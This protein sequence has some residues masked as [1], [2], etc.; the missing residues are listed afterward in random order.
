MRVPPDSR[1]S[2]L[3]ALPVIWKPASLRE[4]VRMIKLSLIVLAAL[5]V[6]PLLFSIR[7]VAAMVAG[8][9]LPVVCAPLPAYRKTAL[10]E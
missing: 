2:R 6:T 3:V 7:T 1:I 9:S 4:P 10:S 5:S 8:N